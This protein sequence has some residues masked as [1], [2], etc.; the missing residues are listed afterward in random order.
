MPSHD[1]NEPAETTAFADE[2]TTTAD[3]QTTTADEQATAADESTA[4]DHHLTAA[5]VER[6]TRRVVREELDQADRSRDTSLW[7]V[8]AGV[9]V[10]FVVIVPLSAL[11]LSSLLDVGI[12]VE[13]VAVLG[14]LAFL[15][16]VAYGWRFP[17]F[18]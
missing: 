18:R 13:S 8:L 3:E 11:V 4:D 12:P 10:G 2:Q 16:L 14:L 9:V 1:D 15:A 6:I 5:D 17:P 7:T